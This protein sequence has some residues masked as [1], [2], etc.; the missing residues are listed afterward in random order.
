MIPH[1]SAGVQ[2]WGQP[3][4]AV[5]TGTGR[6][7]LSQP[8]GQPDRQSEQPSMP[9]AQTQG[10]PPALIDLTANDGDVL[11]REPP[12]KRLK[13]DVHAGSVANDGSPASAGVGESKSTPGATT[14][15][16]PSLSWRARPVWSFQSLLSEIPGSAEING[17]SAA[18]VVQDLKPPPPP[19]F[20]GPPWKFAPTD[21]I[22]SDSA[23]EQD[24]ASAKEVQTTPYH[25]ETPS[26]APVI[27]GESESIPSTRTKRESRL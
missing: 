14:S 7:D 20:S 27:R 5:Y 22:A 11:E 2:S 9:V 21:I 6:A 16:P 26:V 18:G 4:Y 23:G 15:K 19:S 24:G 10:R 1:S 13:I 25:I 12:A 8:L 17:E 3:L